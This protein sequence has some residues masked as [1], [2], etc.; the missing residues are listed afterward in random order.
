[1]KDGRSSYAGIGGITRLGNEAF[2]DVVEGI[3][4]ILIGFTQFEEVERRFGTE[5]RF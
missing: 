2:D 4:I 5:S 1:M 3:E